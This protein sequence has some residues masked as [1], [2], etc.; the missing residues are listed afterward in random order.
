MRHLHVCLAK[1]MHM[2]GTITENMVLTYYVTG[3]TKINHVSTKIDYITTLL[4]YNFITICTNTT[5][6]LPL[7]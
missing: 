7:L 3:P 5:K 1:V 4:Y 2:D 6:C